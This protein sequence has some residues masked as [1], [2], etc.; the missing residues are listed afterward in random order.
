MPRR[1]GVVFLRGTAILLI[2]LKYFS[3]AGRP[4]QAKMGSEAGL[5]KEASQ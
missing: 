1:D 5:I 3:G 4:E 2:S